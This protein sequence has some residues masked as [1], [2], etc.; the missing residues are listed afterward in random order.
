MVFNTRD[1]VTT[2]QHTALDTQVLHINLKRVVKLVYV[3]EKI[4]S[5][6]MQ[7]DLFT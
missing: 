2:I 1:S 4:N 3:L 6:I 7:M 5:A